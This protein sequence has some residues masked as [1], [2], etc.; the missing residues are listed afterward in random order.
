MRDLLHWG[1]GTASGLYA[2]TSSTFFFINFGW[3]VL[4]L[5]V[6]FF[7]LDRVTTYP[8]GEILLLAGSSSLI[9]YPLRPVDILFAPSTM[10]SFYWL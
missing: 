8:S 1:F 2:Y 9:D 4:V 5:Y 6:I 10:P 3:I 7:F